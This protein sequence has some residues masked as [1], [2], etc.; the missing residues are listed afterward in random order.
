MHVFMHGGHSH[1]GGHD[2]QSDQGR[3]P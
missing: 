3:T 2:Q 1:H